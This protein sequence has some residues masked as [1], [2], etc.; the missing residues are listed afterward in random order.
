MT[1]PPRESSV[2]DYPEHDH[3][4][5]VAFYEDN[6]IDYMFGPFST[7]DAAITWAEAFNKRF[8]PEGQRRRYSRSGIYP[9]CAAL[10]MTLHD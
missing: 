5:V 2:P 9:V 10:P 8:A 1:Q 4:F 6:R 7:K 3:Q